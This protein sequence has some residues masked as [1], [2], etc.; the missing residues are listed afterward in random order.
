V[1][2]DDLS[3]QCKSGLSIVDPTEALTAVEL[4]VTMKLAIRSFHPDQLRGFIMYKPVIMGSAT[5]ALALG[6][7]SS[8]SPA[9]A[10]ASV[11]A[12]CVPTGQTTQ[13]DFHFNTAGRAKFNSSKIGEII[14]TCPITTDIRVA[15]YFSLS[16]VD[17][18]G[19]NTRARVTATLRRVDRFT[20]AVSS[21]RGLDSN[22]SSRTTFGV[23]STSVG[24]TGCGEYAFDHDRYYYYAQINMTRS[25]ALHDVS[26]GGVH[27]GTRV[28]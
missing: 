3:R 11:G 28:C 25:T 6:L 17:P 13:F 26:F 15:N 20:G 10:W 19:T 8:P 4:D 16:Y 14:L 22:L 18:D 27:L 23:V 24:T 1:T 12:G 9:L 21:I 5:A 2:Q 7:I